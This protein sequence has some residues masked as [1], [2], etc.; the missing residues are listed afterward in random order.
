M[1]LIVEDGSG[2]ANAN[3]YGA[4]GADATAVLA[5]ARNFAADRG[6]DLG[7]VDPTIAAWLVNAV[8]YLEAFNYIGLPVSPTQSLSWPRKCIF[9]APDTPFP[10]DE[11][12]VQLLA[13]QYQLVIEQFNGI[14]IQ[15]SVDRFGAGGF[16]TSE[17]VDVLET[18]FSEKVGTTSQPTLPKVI[19]LLRGI[20]QTMMPLK[21]VRV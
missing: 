18:K 7:D 13:A 20:I 5:A 14:D 6:I 21:N 16:I 15:P 8:D 3:S 11:I 2:V 4:S 1:P 12:P 19:S 9:L 17:K 10:D